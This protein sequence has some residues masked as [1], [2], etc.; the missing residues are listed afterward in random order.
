[1]NI[2]N[3]STQEAEASRTLRVQGQPGTHQPELHSDNLSRKKRTNIRLVLTDR[4][5]KIL[6]S[7][8]LEK[9]HTLHKTQRSICMEVLM[10]VRKNPC[11][12]L[13]HIRCHHWE[14]SCIKTC[15]SPQQGGIKH[16]R[17][18]TE[19]RFILLSYAKGPN[20][21]LRCSSIASTCFTPRAPWS[22][23]PT[24]EKNKVKV[25]TW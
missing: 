3:H 14:T 22:P 21:R 4:H 2:F 19:S 18:W 13:N 1:M 5:W 20:R 6:L 11:F 12:H 17:C 25:M 24:L 8:C 15:G 7:K 9:L 16:T 23:S 10:A